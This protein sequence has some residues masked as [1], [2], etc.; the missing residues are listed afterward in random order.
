[1]TAGETGRPRIGPSDLGLLLV[2]AGAVAF[3]LRPLFA[4]LAFADG[5]SPAWAGLLTLG[6]T[7]LVCLP[8]TLATLRSGRA[9]LPR[10]PAAW[11]LLTGLFVGVGNLAY[12]YALAGLAVATTTLIYFS[13]PLFVIALGWLFAGLAVTRRTLAAGFLILA[14][15]AAILAPGGWTG[16]DPRLVAL[17]FLAPLSYATLLLLLSRRLV[18]LPLMARIGLITLGASAIM[19][20]VALAGAQGAV[21]TLGAQGWAGVLGLVIVCGF[22]PQL[23]TTIGLPLAGA[24]RGAIAGVLELAT[25]LLVGWLLL[26]EPATAGEALGAAAI[27]CAVL[28]VRRAQ[29]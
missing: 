9:G 24:D 1:V 11:A 12:M 28:L 26:G 7:A 10:G 22:V 5:L 27:L 2:A 19:L 16:G 4:R 14:G 25:A 3:G 17:C 13:Y 21:P 8:A 6:P 18:G 23:V 29:T 20:P 15:C